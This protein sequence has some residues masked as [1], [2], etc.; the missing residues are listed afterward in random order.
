MKRLIAALAILILTGGYTLA[1]AKDKAQGATKVKPKLALMIQGK[2]TQ[3]ILP[4]TEKDVPGV[5]T[6]YT[7]EWSGGQGDIMIVGGGSG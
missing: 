6:D 1:N 2:V 7:F 5:G 4:K 3:E